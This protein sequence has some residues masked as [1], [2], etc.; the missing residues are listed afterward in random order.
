MTRHSAMP[1]LFIGH[2]SPMNALGGNAFAA[3]LNRLGEALP[4]PEAILLVSAHWRTRGT[5]VLNHN[6]PKMIYDM[7]GFPKEL[8]EIVYPAK[9]HAG[10]SARVSELIAPLG[11]AET[12]DWGFD[13][14]AW[15]VLCHLFPKADVPVVMLSLDKK[16]R[17]EDHFRVAEAL[18][19]LRNEGV[20]IV[21]SGNVTHNLGD[22]DWDGNGKPFAWAEQFDGIVKKALDA[23]DLPTLLSFKGVPEKLHRHALPTLEHYHPLIYALGASNDDDRVSYPYEEMQNGSLSMRSVLFGS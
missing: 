1:T 3:A 7:S 22:M 8:Y 21:G 14:G 12:L 17:T 20:L 2:G 9:G 11:G 16:A 4:R 6:E 23:R 10:V 18:K 19:P 13:H 5:Q 15:A